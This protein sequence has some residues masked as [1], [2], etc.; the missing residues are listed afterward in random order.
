MIFK[1]RKSCYVPNKNKPTNA[2][3]CIGLGILLQKTPPG[4]EEYS[5][6]IFEKN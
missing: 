5:G 3:Y 6:Q 4:V 1:M 2:E